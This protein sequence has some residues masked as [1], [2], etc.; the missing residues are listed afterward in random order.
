MKYNHKHVSGNILTVVFSRQFRRWWCWSWKTSSSCSS[1]SIPD[2]LAWMRSSSFFLLLMNAAPLAFFAIR[3]RANRAFCK[4]KV[5]YL[6]FTYHSF[7]KY[8][9]YIFFVSRSK[10]DVIY[11]SQTLV[12]CRDLA[13]FQWFY[14]HAWALFGWG[15][16]GHVPLMFWGVGDKRHFVPPPHVLQA[17]FFLFSA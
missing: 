12:G 14:S 10:Y 7:K 17:R 9:E 4:N 11:Y 3:M 2:S 13:W 8:V 6:Y 15:T 5:D 1:T 16:G